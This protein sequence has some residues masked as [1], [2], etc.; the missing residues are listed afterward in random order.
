MPSRANRHDLGQHYGCRQ[1]ERIAEFEALDRK[2]A[3]LKEQKRNA[4]KE[5]RAKGKKAEAQGEFR[6]KPK[7]EKRQSLQQ[8]EGGKE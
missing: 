8:Q 5:D 1:T 4:P 6:R 2:K 3:E 7:R